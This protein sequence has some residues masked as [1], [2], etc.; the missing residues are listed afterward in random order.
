MSLYT[1]CDI[2]FI[3][4]VEYSFMWFREFED[5]ANTKKTDI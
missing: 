4:F 1:K 5:F 2:K 3:L